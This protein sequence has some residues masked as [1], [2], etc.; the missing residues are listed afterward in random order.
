MPLM[1]VNNLCQFNCKVYR[2]PQRKVAVGYEVTLSLY[3]SKTLR[4][5]ASHYG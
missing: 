1:F 2:Y 3:F 4:L 5:Y